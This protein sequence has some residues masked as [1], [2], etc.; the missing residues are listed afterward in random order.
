MVTV[1]EI[2]M[3]LVSY[4]MG[5]EDGYADGINVVE[6]EEGEDYT[7]TDTNADGNIVITKEE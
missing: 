5:M 6:F 2:N 7:F 4:I 1:E 3:D